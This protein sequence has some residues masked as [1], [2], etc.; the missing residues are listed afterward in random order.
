[1][2]TAVLGSCVFGGVYLRGSSNP[3]PGPLIPMAPR[4]VVCGTRRETRSTL[5]HQGQGKRKG[6][7][8]DNTDT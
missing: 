1:M 6:Q 2:T 5:K 7:T 4:R 8:L 3:E